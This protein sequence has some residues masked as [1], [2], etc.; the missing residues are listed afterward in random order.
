[1]PTET[2]SRS[3]AVTPARSVSSV[4]PSSMRSPGSS[5]VGCS[6]AAA[7]DARRRSSSRGRRPPSRRRAGAP[8]RACARRWR[9]RAR[10]RSRGAA[11]RRPARPT[12][13]RLPSSDEQR[14]AR[15]AGAGALLQRLA[16]AV[17]GRVD[18]R[19]AALGLATA[20]PPPVSGGCDEPRLDAELAEAQPL[21]GA[22]LDRR[23]RHRARSARGAR[24]PAG[25]RPARRAA[26]ARS[27]RSARGPPATDRR[28][29][30][31]A[32]RRARRSA[33]CAPPSRA[34]ACAR[35]RPGGPPSGRHGRTCPRRGRRSCFPGSCSTLMGSTPAM[36]RNVR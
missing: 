26:R 20:R 21:V 7:V 4:V 25:S 14:P 12:T 23:P 1:M 15:L 19:V 10:R 2:G 27:P 22:E 34:R 11:E 13:M 6:D 17:G 24:A 29:T 18:H 28:R 32:R 5:G 8:R 16:D 35:S 9:R 3:S 33:T 31:S 36:L 30:R